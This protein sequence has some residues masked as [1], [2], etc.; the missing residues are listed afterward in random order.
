MARD[1]MLQQAALPV[2]KLA[3]VVHNHFVKTVK[4]TS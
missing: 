1:V 3:W 2:I 4:M